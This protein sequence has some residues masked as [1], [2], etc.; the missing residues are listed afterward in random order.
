MALNK[1]EQWEKMEYIQ[2]LSLFYNP[3]V[4]YHIFSL[5][6][7]TLSNIGNLDSYL[8]EAKDFRGVMLELNIT[9]TSLTEPWKPWSLG[10][11]ATTGA[12]A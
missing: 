9:S 5:T 8:P 7:G 4:L 2:G 1:A 10:L 12:L 3:V 6:H 11:K